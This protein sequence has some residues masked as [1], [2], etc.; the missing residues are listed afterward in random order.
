MLKLVNF[1]ENVHHQLELGSFNPFLCLLHADIS[2]EVCAKWISQRPIV[3]Q[4]CFNFLNTLPMI[5]ESIFVIRLYLQ[6]KKL[7]CT[8]WQLNSP[9]AC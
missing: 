5:N 9:L 2:T 6:R 4:V 1:I 3:I 7:F 8:C